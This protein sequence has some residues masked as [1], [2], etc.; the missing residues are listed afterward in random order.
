MTDPVPLHVQAAT[1]GRITFDVAYYGDGDEHVTTRVVAPSVISAMASAHAALADTPDYPAKYGKAVLV[2]IV[3]LEA[4]AA[5][6]EHLA[7]LIAQWED[8]LE[9]FEGA[10]FVLA[11][12]IWHRHDNGL[13][14]SVDDFSDEEGMRN[15]QICSLRST[16]TV[17]AMQPLVVIPWYGD[18]LAHDRQYAMLKVVLAELVL[19]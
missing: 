16:E 2:Q 8:A 5:E 9:V 13:W 6:R 1:L 7:P 15:V 10:G 14:A 11:H 12:G 19:P 17:G 18:G 4:E 3:D